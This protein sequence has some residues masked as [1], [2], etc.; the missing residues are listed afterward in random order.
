MK[1]VILGLSIIMLALLSFPL[2]T[3]AA[4]GE[5]SI[6]RRAFNAPDNISDDM[7]AL[8]FYLV[9]P[10]KDDYEKLKSI[11][12]WI[13]SHIA[14]DSYV[15]DVKYNE[16][17]GSYHY[18]ILKAKAGICRDFALLFSQMAQLAGIKGVKVVHGYVVKTNRLRKTYPKKSLGVGHAWNEVKMGGRTFFVDTTFMAPMR[19][20]QDGKKYKS[21]LKHKMEL[22]K[23]GRSRTQVDE[24][25]R[26]GYFDFTPADEVK[27]FGEV[28]WKKQ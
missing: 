10:Y 23:R 14:Y 20:G 12:Y 18:D 15:Y 19:I 21:S 26:V 13:A 1:K 4:A 16:K 25:I 9:K 5:A 8:T 28:H 22:K 11:A 17:T 6:R 3:H 7:R 24:N 27:E 2:Q